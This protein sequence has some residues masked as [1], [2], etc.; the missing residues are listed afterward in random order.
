MPLSYMP[1]TIGLTVIVGT[2]TSEQMEYFQRFL[3]IIILTLKKEEFDTHII[4]SKMQISKSSKIIRN[5]NCFIT[6]S[7][8]L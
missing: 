8:K 7:W 4:N 2:V 5:G 1:S 6:I 3:S